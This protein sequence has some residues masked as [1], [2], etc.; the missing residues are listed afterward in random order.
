MISA[1]PQLSIF[2]VAANWSMLNGKSM[3]NAKCS[4]LTAY[5]GDF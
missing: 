5:E 1:L 3:L 4:M 2:N